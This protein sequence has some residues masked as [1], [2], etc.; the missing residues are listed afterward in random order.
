LDPNSPEQ[1]LHHALAFYSLDIDLSRPAEPDYP[2]FSG[3]LL[4]QRSVEGALRICSE[5]AKRAKGQESSVVAS[6]KVLK[7]LLKLGEK[8]EDAGVVVEWDSERWFDGFAGLL[9]RV[10]LAF[11]LWRI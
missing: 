4:F 10:R 7:R 1:A 9:L 5:V 8:F 3:P 2:A 11:V 6:L